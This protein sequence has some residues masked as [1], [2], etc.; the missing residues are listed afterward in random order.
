MRL[1]SQF[2]ETSVRMFASSPIFG[3]GVGRYFE[4]SSQ[5]MPDEIRALY[6]AE[7]AHNYYAQ[8]FAELG[9]IGGAIFLWLIGAGLIAGWRRAGGGERDATAVA[10]LAGSAGYLVTCLTGHPFL[11]AEAALP[12]W[13]AFGALAAG[14]QDGP[15]ASTLKRYRIVPAVVVVLLAVGLARA[16]AVYAGTVTPP[17]ERGFDSEGTAADGTRFR[18]VGPHVVTYAPPGPGFFRMT[19]RAPDRPLTRPMV[20][21]TAIA[22]RVVDRRELV[23]GRWETVEIPVREQLAGP[24]RRIDVRVTPSWMDQRK[25]ARRATPIEVALT[26]M[27]S[28]LR[29]VRPGGR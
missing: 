16:C 28:E 6:G 19:L 21:E 15:P 25:L 4:R 8:A 27:V 18:W 24:V 22:G 9:I 17:G 20:V 7:N 11:V 14:A 29:W 2:S 10:L 13:G 26:A 1:R 5:F 12:F 23:P 3:V